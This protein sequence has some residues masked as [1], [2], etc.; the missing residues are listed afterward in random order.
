[1]PGSPTRS[2]AARQNLGPSFLQ[3]TT[4]T[5]S[6]HLHHSRQ[7]RGET[8]RGC[9][10]LS[11]GFTLRLTDF[12]VSNHSAFGEHI[13]GGQR[14]VKLVHVWI[15]VKDS[16]MGQRVATMHDEEREVCASNRQGLDAGLTSLS[17]VIRQEGIYKASKQFFCYMIGGQ[18]QMTWVFTGL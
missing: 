9:G 11:N 6:S 7:N 16:W 3:T 14:L 5:C 10:H 13:T 15:F 17:I 8:V 18:Y 1:M 12:W 4:P 2:S